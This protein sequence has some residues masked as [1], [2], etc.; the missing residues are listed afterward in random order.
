M[1][2]PIHDTASVHEW[3]KTETIFNH[4]VVNDLG[5]YDH[6]I[7]KGYV[8]QSQ[9]ILGGWPLSVLLDMTVLLR[10]SRDE[11][12][13]LSD[14]TLKDVWATKSLLESIEC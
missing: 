12:G 6:G 11:P 13:H 14:I 5:L 1:N 7:G 9:L 8:Q 2:T 3:S 10:L 4:E